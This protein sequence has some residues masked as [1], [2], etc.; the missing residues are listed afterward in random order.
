M[1]LSKLYVDENGFLMLGEPYRLSSIV[2]GIRLDRAN[3]KDDVLFKVVFTNELGLKCQGYSNL[4]EKK[5]K[6]E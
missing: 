4:C 2:D 3:S 5:F 6:Y 1:E